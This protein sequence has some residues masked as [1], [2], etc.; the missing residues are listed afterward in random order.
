MGE[1]D[2][3]ASKTSSKLKKMLPVIIIAVVLLVMI[4]PSVLERF[5]G[6]EKKAP[7]AR[8]VIQCSECAV[9]PVDT[10][11]PAPYFHPMPCSTCFY[12]HS[13]SLFKAVDLQGAKFPVN[14]KDPSE[15]GRNDP[16]YD[17]VPSPCF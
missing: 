16:L 13:I 6:P 17:Q 1:G 8:F 12:P 15:I 3:A 7:P 4:T 5:N 11:Y 9:D 2:K 10:V 14:F